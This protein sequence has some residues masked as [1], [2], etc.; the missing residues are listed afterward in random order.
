[1]PLPDLPPPAIDTPLLLAPGD[2]IQKGWNFIKPQLVVVDI[3][4]IVAAAVSFAL[5]HIP[6]AGAALAFVWQIVICSGLYYYL[7]RAGRGE[8]ASFGDMLVPLQD[9]AGGVIVVSLLSGLAVILGLVLLIVPGL[10]VGIALSLSLPLVVL[11]TVS[12]TDAISLSWKIVNHHLV[13]FIVLGLVV[14]A[15]NLG[16]A[17]LLG[18]GLFVTV[19]VTLGIQLVILTQLLQ[20]ATTASQ[21]R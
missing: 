4:I 7:W 12:A 19:P 6:L 21:P 17:L 2:M 5:H 8:P 11:T 15:M 9:K 16:G 18:L 20:P 13:D 1:M 14:L 3:I 10:Y